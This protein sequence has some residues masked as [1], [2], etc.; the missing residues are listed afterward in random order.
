MDAPHVH[1]WSLGR[2]DATGGAW[3]ECG[4]REE[5]YFDGGGGDPVERGR[6]GAHALALTG[7]ARRGHRKREDE[8]K[9]YHAAAVSLAGHI[10]KRPGTEKWARGGE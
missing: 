10:E 2:P 3:G 6:A 7:L 9:A 4:C 5:R 1:R 8:W